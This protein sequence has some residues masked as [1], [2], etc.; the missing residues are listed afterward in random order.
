M[1]TSDLLRQLEQSLLDP[2]VRRDPDS[3]ATLLAEDPDF[4]WKYNHLNEN[5]L[6][7]TLK[8]AHHDASGTL[9]QTLPSASYLAS[10][11]SSP[12]A[13][14][15]SL[16]YLLRHLL[17]MEARGEIPA[18]RSPSRNRCHPPFVFL[19]LPSPKA[20]LGDPEVRT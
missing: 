11:H 3:V 16:A 19:R 17:R 9:M 1:T 20:D 14:P 5:W 15:S 7:A 10:Q 4:L 8:R 2:A 6:S 12:L 18:G 13:G